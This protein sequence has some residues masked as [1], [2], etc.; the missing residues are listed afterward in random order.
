MMIRNARGSLHIDFC[1]MK[2][3]CGV[4][5]LKPVLICHFVFSPYLPLK[6]QRYIAVL[7]FEEDSQQGSI[8]APQPVST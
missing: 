2:F 5:F 8:A 4:N 3:V 1:W 6:F 7:V